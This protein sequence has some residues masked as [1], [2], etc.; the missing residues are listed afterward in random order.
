MSLL[1]GN[2]AL[3]TKAGVRAVLSRRR[4]QDI[5]EPLPRG[6]IYS[7]ERHHNGPHVWVGG[8]L[9]AL[10]SATWDPVFFMHHAY[11]DAV[12]ARFRQLQIQSG[13]NPETNYPSTSQ[14]GH[15]RN[16]VIS[17]GTLFERVTNIQAMANR[18]ANLVT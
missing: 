2:S 5:S 7:L 11:V 13:I 12:W 8:H 17:F 15:R 16:D 18:F 14:R 3:F 1:K 9:S 4:F 10:N 6:N